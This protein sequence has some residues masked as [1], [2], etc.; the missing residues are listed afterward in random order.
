MTA[1][2]QYKSPFWGLGAKKTLHTRCVQG[3]FLGFITPLFYCFLT[4]GVF[5]DGAASI[6][7]IYFLQKAA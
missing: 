4:A 1:P 6:V 3:L 2:P 5:T 7:P